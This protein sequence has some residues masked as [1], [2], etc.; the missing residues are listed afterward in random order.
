M[1]SKNKI[2][3]GLCQNVSHERM[4]I[5]YF[6]DLQSE[7]FRITSMMRKADK[8]KGLTFFLNLLT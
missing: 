6:F 3:S 2:K 5:N 4:L 1:E 8:K 7:I